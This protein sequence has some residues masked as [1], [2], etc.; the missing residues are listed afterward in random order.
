MGEANPS[1]EIPVNV[2]TIGAYGGSVS[3]WRRV[4]SSPRGSADA[5]STS[6]PA[7]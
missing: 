5:P 1:G 6:S 7:L 2:A 3:N 4:S